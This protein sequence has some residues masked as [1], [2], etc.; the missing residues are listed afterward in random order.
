M[1]CE[2]FSIFWKKIKT[3]IIVK[4]HNNYLQCEKGVQD[5]LLSYFEYCQIWLNI[6]MDDCHLSNIIKLENKQIT[7]WNPLIIGLV[8]ILKELLHNTREI[9]NPTHFS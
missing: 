7:P 2:N 4:K 6:L 1:F 3:K 9:S 8:F 5:C